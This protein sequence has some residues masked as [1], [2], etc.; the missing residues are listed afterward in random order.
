MIFM[1]KYRLVTDVAGHKIINLSITLVSLLS[2]IFNFAFPH[3]VLASGVS[4]NK[5]ISFD[6]SSEIKPY[7]LVAVKSVSLSQKDEQPK[8]LPIEANKANYKI[9]AVIVA[10]SQKKSKITVASYQQPKYSGGLDRFDDSALDAALLAGEGTVVAKKWVTMTAYSSTPDQTDSSPFIT[11]S[12][13]HVHDG[14]V[15]AN[16]LPF[17]TRIR[18][19]SLYPEKIFT[20]EDRMNAR[21]DSRVDIWFQTREEAIKFGLK[22]VEIEI[23][24]R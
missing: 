7:S 15:A 22:R 4:R 12:N 13:T 14:I 11:A 5:A 17:G 18:I 8:L 6:Y 16:F 9:S 24:K 20:V 19:P 3:L 10:D 2:F 23:V 21:F 1:G